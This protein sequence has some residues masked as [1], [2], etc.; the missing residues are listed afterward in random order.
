MH[1]CD[2]EAGDGNIYLFIIRPGA[3]L[4]NR[5]IERRFQRSMFNSFNWARKQRNFP[6]PVGIRL[7]KIAL[8]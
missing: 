5:T 2:L 1:A 8:L 3:R 6:D 4:K 7:T